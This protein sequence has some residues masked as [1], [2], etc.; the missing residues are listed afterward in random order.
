MKRP[1]IGVTV[2]Q[3]IE[4]HLR[5]KFNGT[6]LY[7]SEGVL[8]AGGLPVMLPVLPGTEGAQLEHLDGILLVGGVDVDP[9]HFGAEHERGLGEI[10]AARDSF[11]LELYRLA[12]AAGKPVLG[13]CRGFQLINIAE[14]G[15]LYQH[16][17][18]HK[19]LWA[20]HSQTANPPALGHRVS[21][22]LGSRLGAQYASDTIRVNSHH[23]QGIKD[24]APNLTA[25]A[26]APD[27]LVEGLEG[28]SVIAVQWHPEL[29]F[30]LHEEHLAP[31]SAL[32]EM[33]QAVRV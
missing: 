13:I 14:G 23:H 25:T 1:R 24:V 19:D 27:G 11:E 7:Y 16:I 5:R 28:D 18:A 9:H 26:F 31:F 30:S 20:D 8:N 15:T 3:Q 17:P 6:T 32:I 22:K 21:L 10:D 29:L 12:R 33:C 4:P 2:A